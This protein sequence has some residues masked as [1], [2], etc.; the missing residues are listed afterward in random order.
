M[1]ARLPALAC[2]EHYTFQLAGWVC[3]AACLEET[4]DQFGWRLLGPGHFTLRD[5]RSD[6]NPKVDYGTV[7]YAWPEDGSVP[8]LNKCMQCSRARSTLGAAHT[9]FELSCTFESSSRRAYT[10]Q[11]ALRHGVSDSFTIAP[12]VEISLQKRDLYELCGESHHQHQ[13]AWNSSVR[14]ESRE[15]PRHYPRPRCVWGT[16]RDEDL[17]EE[18]LSAA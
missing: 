17:E 5:G 13:A 14:E 1:T 9:L 7:M 15:Q 11:C 3:S 4:R 6:V 18:Q 16:P 12:G 10:V 2:H 8:S